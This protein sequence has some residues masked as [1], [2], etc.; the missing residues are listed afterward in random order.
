MGNETTSLEQARLAALERLQAVTSEPDQV[1]QELVDEVRMLFGADLCMVNLVLECVQ[2]FR[3]WSGDLPADMVR[4]RQIPREHSMCRF[5]VERREPVLVPDFRE[6]AEFCNPVYYNPYGFRFYVGVPLTS[7]EGH[8]LGSL[9]L[10]HRE[11]LPITAREV[12]ALRGY[13]RAVSARLELIAALRRERAITER[14]RA[15]DAAREE[16]ARYKILAETASEVIITVDETANIVFA[17]RA[18]EAVFGYG[19]GELSGQPLQLLVPQHLRTAHHSGFHRYLQTGTRRVTARSVELPGL[20]KDGHT[21]PLELSFADF[22][23]NGKRYVTAIGRDV[24]QRRVFEQQL[25]EMAFYDGLTGLPNRVL[26]LE[27]LSQALNRM[28]PDIGAVSVLYMDLDNFMVLN[29]SLGHEL[30]DQLL[31]AVSNRIKALLDERTTVARI[32]GDEFA[33][34]LQP[35]ASDCAEAL[36]LADRLLTALKEPFHLNGLEIYS[37]I[38]VGIAVDRDGS[39]QAK[40]LI[41]YANVAM[42]RAKQKGKGQVLLFE[43]RMIA[44]V[45]ERLTLETELRHALTHGELSLVYQPIVSLVSGEMEGVEA[46]VRWNHPKHGPISPARFIPV[47]EECGLIVPIGR[48]V[49]EEA[50][51]QARAW[52]VLGG[53][54]RP[55]WVSVN[56]SARQFQTNDL[57]GQVEEILQGSGLDPSLLKLEITETSL[58]L[59]ASATIEILHALKRLGIHLAIDDFGTGYSSLSYLQRF[60]VNTL[61]IDR[62]FID[63]I[64]EDLDTRSIVTVAILCARSLN[65]SV[66]AEGIETAQQLELLGEMAC[67]SGQGYFF[68]RP[69]PAAEITA[70][71]TSGMVWQ[72][73][74]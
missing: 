13:S 44:N 17:N 54:R 20:H 43:E 21:V 37:G 49:L 41:R 61:K 65:L 30:G 10:Y 68:A 74:S 7:P 47:A 67:T 55:L 31:K 18:A 51:R 48:F 42:L 62:S 38:S 35:V 56:L 50:C 4:Q 60:P 45:V 36:A 71:L 59:D 25:Q 24:T 9:C 39:L 22:T 70:R 2:F 16:E 58:M 53:R 1:L 27:R 14:N 5:V 15:D 57:V 23:Q 26:F 19:A 69:L 12:A 8:V 46:L 32:A 34:L 63:R 29:D 6:S 72:T 40:D 33:I 11:P 73:T 3:A 64:C 66:V 28:H 52:Q